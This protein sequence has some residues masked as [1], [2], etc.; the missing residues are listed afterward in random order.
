MIT[1]HAM[2]K[3]TGM[4]LIAEIKAAWPHLPV[5][6]ASGY[7]ELPESRDARVHKLN[8]PFTEAQLA[9]ALASVSTR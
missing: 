5:I 4:Q 2:P 7:A 1:D 6:L 3:M 8:K 9:E